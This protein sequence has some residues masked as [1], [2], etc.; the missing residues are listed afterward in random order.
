MVN[1]RPFSPLGDERV[2]G[3]QSSVRHDREIRSRTPGGP[4][5]HFVSGRIRLRGR[6]CGVRLPVH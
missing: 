3:C 5:S 2:F 1:A 6:S 4:N